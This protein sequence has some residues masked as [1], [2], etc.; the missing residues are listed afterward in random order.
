[1][2]TIRVVGAVERKKTIIIRGNHLKEERKLPQKRGRG[3]FK[4]SPARTAGEI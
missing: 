3:I 1:M 4:V 2:K